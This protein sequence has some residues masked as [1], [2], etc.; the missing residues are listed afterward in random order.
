M[1]FINGVGK[2]TNKGYFIKMGEN[3]IKVFGIH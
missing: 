3:L 2:I 1:N